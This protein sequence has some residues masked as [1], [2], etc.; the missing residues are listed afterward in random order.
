MDT[1]IRRRKRATAFRMTGW[2]AVASM[3]TLSLVGPGAAGVA[4]SGVAPRTATPATLAAP[5]CGIVPLD[6]ELIID[7]SGSMGETNTAS[8]TPSHTRIWYAKDAAVALVNEL[9]KVANGGVGGSDLHHVGLSSYGNSTAT[10]NLPL[11]TSSAATVNAAINA[12]GTNG[13]TPFRQ[14]MAA[15]A[16]DM[17]ANERGLV[18]GIQTQHVIIF[19]S[20]GRPNP[21]NTSG[22][23]SRPT[24][25]NISAFM[26]AAGTVYSI[27][28][29]QGGTGLSQV[30]TAL[31]ASLAKPAAKYTQVTTGSGLPTVFA[32]IVQEILCPTPEP[33]VAP[34]VE[35]SVAPS[36]T[37]TGAVEA[38][39][40]TP[41]VTPPPTDTLGGTTGQP[42]GD[43]WRIA[44]LGLAALLA[45]LLIFS[46][47]RTSPE[48][49]RR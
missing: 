37:P 42:A 12:M 46:P 45:S 13:N 14:G 27:G 30:D 47:S 31:M 5:A 11:G 26:A 15:G 1:N 41:H 38:A 43:T 28:I 6:V 18:N 48:R 19:L 22:S 39:T 35:P 17:T 36:P 20:D 25:P 23:G 34:S 21:D 33:S 10:V 7:R 49:R 16:G 29:G 8:G 3:V 40:G 9:N 2:L 44:L 4:A 24:A 32:G